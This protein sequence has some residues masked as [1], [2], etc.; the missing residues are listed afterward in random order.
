MKD[1]A[2]CTLL[3]AMVLLAL[4]ASQYGWGGLLTGNRTPPRAQAGAGIEAVVYDGVTL[5]LTR[6]YASAQAV[7][8]DPDAF[9]PADRARA[10]R[11]VRERP[12][13]TNVRGRR[14]LYTLMAELRFPGHTVIANATELPDGTTLH[15]ASVEIPYAGESRLLVYLG[16]GDLFVLADDTTAAAKLGVVR[17]TFN[18]DQIIYLNA[19]SEPVLSR[20]AK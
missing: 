16:G 15:F 6:S 17:A 2:L 9:S 10:A 3:A 13:P 18:A 11:L 8:N 1:V 12:V 14:A 7:R 19:K 5:P 20:P 4:A